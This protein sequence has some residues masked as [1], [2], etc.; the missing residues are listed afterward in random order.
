LPFN[1]ELKVLCDVYFKMMQKKVNGKPMLPSTI[2]QVADHICNNYC[3]P[4]GSLLSNPTVRT[5][6]SSSRPESR[7]K[8]D[9]EINLDD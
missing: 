7:P 1:G 4:D 8:S 3:Y 5:Y 6:L 2:A 9:A